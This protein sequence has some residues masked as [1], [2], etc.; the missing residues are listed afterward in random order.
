MPTATSP[1]PPQGE[2]NISVLYSAEDI[3]RRIAGMAREIAAVMPREFVVIAL[4]KGSFVFAADLIRA[5]HHCRLKPQVD[6]MTLS[7]YG[8]GTQSSGT[9][10]VLRDTTEII[11]GK[12][13]LLVDDILESGRTLVHAKKLLQERGAEDVRVAVFLEKP[14]KRAVQVEADF[15]GYRVPDKFV[16]GYG[17]DFANAYRELPYVGAIE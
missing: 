7:S 1:Q 16:V 15:V 11:Q 9:V 14:G 3:S 10:T 5:L 2:P 4:L 13:I 17:L 6:F 8:G 12:R